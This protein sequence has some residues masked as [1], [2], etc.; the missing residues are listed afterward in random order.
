MVG[1]IEQTLLAALVVVVMFGMGA[2]LAPGDFRDALV[3]PRAL[4]VGLLSQ[5]GIMP[6]LGFLM[7]L[8][9]DLPEPVALGLLI[10]SC[11]PGGVTSNMFTYFAR[12]DLALSIVMTATSTLLG[13]LL[14]PLLLQHYAAALDLRIPRENIVASLVALVLPVVAG[15]VLRQWNARAARAAEAAGSALGMILVGLIIVIWV[16]RN[17]QLLLATAPVIHF[18][19]VTLGALG[20]LAGFGAARATRLA[21]RTASAVA[22]EAGIQNFPLAFAII[23]LSFPA[24]RQQAMIS[25][26]ALYTLYIML[27]AALA[28]MALRRTNLRLQT[29]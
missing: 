26:G 27:T 19:A 18:A 3:R 7:V 17:W 11:M 25:V 15:M 10:L 29:P 12:G 16:P 20:I 5:Y 14:I 9:L 13:L 22:L 21:P 23:V 24:E 6:F 4:V 1:P 2:S 8:A 28:S